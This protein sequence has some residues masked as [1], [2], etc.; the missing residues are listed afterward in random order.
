MEL[1]YPAPWV[2][3]TQKVPLTIHT[4]VSQSDPV[5]EWAEKCKY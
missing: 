1:F 5:I 3:L 2:E 4:L